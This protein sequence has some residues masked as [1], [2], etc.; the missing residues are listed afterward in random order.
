MNQL[1]WW[2]YWDQPGI[3]WGCCRGGVGARMPSGDQLGWVPICLQPSPSWL[4]GLLECQRASRAAAVQGPGQ[5]S[6]LLKGFYRAEHN[7][8]EVDTVCKGPL[9]LCGQFVFSFEDS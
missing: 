9:V 5:C 7:K 6:I 2:P 3:W 1:G 8:R 4:P